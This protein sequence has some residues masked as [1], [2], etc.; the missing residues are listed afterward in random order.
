MI[1]KWNGS[2]WSA[3]GSGMNNSV[4]SLV[5]DDSGNLYAVGSFLFAGGVYARYVA[6]WDGNN[7]SALGSGTNISVM[8]AAFGGSGNLCSLP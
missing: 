4:N 6:K 8:S 1:A 3:L 5:F 7:W 2:S